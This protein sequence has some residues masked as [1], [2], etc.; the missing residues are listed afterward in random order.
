MNKGIIQSNAI[1]V[2]K[3]M[4]DESVDCVI[5]SPP[6][7]SLRKYGDDSNELGQ[8]KTFQEYVVKLVEIFNEVKRVLK[9]EGT[10]WVNIADTYSGNKKGKTDNKVSNYLKEEVAGINKQTQFISDKCLCNIPHRLAIAMTDNGWIHRNTVIWYKRNAMPSSVKDR[11][12]VDYELILFFTKSKK[13][14]F[15]QQFEPYAPAS[16]VRYRQAL[17]VNRFYNSKEPYKNNTPYSGKFDG[18]KNH[19]RARMQ[20]Y[21]RGQG[22]VS[23]RGDNVDGLVV[24]G[25]TNGRN[26]RCVWDIPT[27]PSDIPHFAMYPE[28]LVERMINAGC[29]KNGIVLDP[30]VGAGNTLITAKKLGR[31]FMGIELYEKYVKICEERLKAVQPSLLTP[32][33][34]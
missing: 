8:E 6:Y 15:E 32:T 29:S 34:K 9:K 5:T 21:K 24:G 12:T 19:E 13:Y 14:Y 20:R 23:S 26:M 7:W 30:F 22:S 11:F 4:E 17:R 31:R 18:N 27:K 25:K 1:D 3:Q 16:D 33:N 2:L 10:C 28:T